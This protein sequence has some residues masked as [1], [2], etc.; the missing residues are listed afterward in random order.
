[1]GPSDAEQRVR[2]ALTIL[3]A[4]SSDRPVHLADLERQMPDLSRAE[5]QGALESLRGGMLVQQVRG[6]W[7]SRPP[8]VGQDATSAKAQAS[9]VF[10]RGRL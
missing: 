6:G 10:Q 7:L 2:I 5:I 8:P 3:Q 1:M 9:R 4:R